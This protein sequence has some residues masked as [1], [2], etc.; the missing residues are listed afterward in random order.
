MRLKKE[1]PERMKYIKAMLPNV[2]SLET[3]IL[4][5]QKWLTEG[6]TLLQDHKLEGTPDGAYARLERHKVG[7]II[8]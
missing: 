4:D 5:L 8:V 3:G 2:E 1:I 6:E 7:K